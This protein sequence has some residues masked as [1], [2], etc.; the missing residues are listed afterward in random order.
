VGRAVCEGEAGEGSVAGKGVSAARGVRGRGSETGFAARGAG[1]V[2]VGRVSDGADGAGAVA[3]G[4]IG[5]VSVALGAGVGAATLRSVAEGGGGADILAGGGCIARGAGAVNSGLTGGGATMSSAFGGLC[6]R[7]LALGGGAGCVRD[8][9]KVPQ[10]LTVARERSTGFIVMLMINV[11]KMAACK[12]T[13]M[14]P[15]R[16]G[17]GSDSASLRNQVISHMGSIA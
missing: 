1:G 8:T 10:S 16:T 11:P 12:A 2:C 17:I 15:A 5:A 9:G 14:M 13:T 6:F 4:G 7:A 3:T